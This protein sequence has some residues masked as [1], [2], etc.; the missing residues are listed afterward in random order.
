MSDRTI[1]QIGVKGLK[2]PEF[3]CLKFKLG[4]KCKRNFRVFSYDKESTI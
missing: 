4:L 1:S 2:K 3:I